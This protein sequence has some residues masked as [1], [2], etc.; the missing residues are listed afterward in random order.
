MKHALVK[1]SFIRGSTVAASVGYAKK[2]SMHVHTLAKATIISG[3]KFCDFL[4]L[5]G[6]NLAILVV[7]HRN[8][9]V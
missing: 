8:C 3:Y 2:N 4:D 5:A 1:L 9:T 6:T 7:Y